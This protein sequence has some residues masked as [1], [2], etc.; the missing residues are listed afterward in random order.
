MCDR[1]STLLE[2]EGLR[3][4]LEENIMSLAKPNAV[5][6]IANELISLM[7]R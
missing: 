5:K 4:V 6:E 7:K 3:S 1:I 2:N